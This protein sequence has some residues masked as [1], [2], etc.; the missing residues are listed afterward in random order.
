MRRILLSAGAAVA[1]LALAPAAR[2]Q[3]DTDKVV[4]KKRASEWAT[5]LRT[6]KNP[7]VRRRAVIALDLAGPKTRKV[8]EVVGT[9]VRE[10]KD[11]QVRK[12]AAQVLGRLG[13]K[14]REM[15]EANSGLKFAFP[16]GVDALV[17]ALQRDK[18]DAVR[19]LAATALG[20]FGP[21]ARSAV[22]PLAAALKDSSP[23]VRAAA[24]DALGDIGADA[25]QAVADLA[26]AVRNNKGKEGLRVRA[27]AV[28]SLGRLGE[29]A[30]RG[31]PALCALL[32]EPDET[33]DAARQA[34]SELR[35]A[36]ADALGAIGDPSALPALGK[37]L[38]S[39]MVLQEV[40]VG[41]RKRKQP[42]DEVLTRAL[43]AAINRFGPERKVLVPTLVKATSP[44]QDK[45]VR[46]QAMHALGRLG[47]HLGDSRKAAIAGLRQGLADQAAEVR[48]AAI[49]ALRELGPG[50]IG[51]ELKAVRAELVLA[52]N[53][54]EKL[55]SDAAEATIKELD[56]KP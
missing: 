54:P 43:M 38:E 7:K 8:F 56:R 23:V 19:E 6:D 41:M 34:Q 13:A 17:F 5:I 27:N 49:V 35:R 47:K 11:E 15:K 9:A 36:T 21:E 40:T 30:G 42:K 50:V 39:A 44:S 18:S 12:A 29:R 4:L 31:V 14:A 48:L 26:D 52:K 53:A 2:S 45:F 24:A 3:D 16:A 1:L 33:D 37:A 20:R 55:I 51:D 10:D 32:A 46:G 22:F 25:R 28:S